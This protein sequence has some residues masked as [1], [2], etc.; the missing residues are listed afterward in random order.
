MSI[1][2]NLVKSYS[3]GN[4]SNFSKCLIA[5]CSAALL[6]AGTAQAAATYTTEDNGATLVVTV[7]AE[8]ATLDSSQIVAGVTKIAKRGS[9]K[10]TSVDISSYTGDFDIEEG[11]WCCTDAKQFGAASKSVDSGTI[12]VRDGASI[13][14]AGT[15]TKP[16]TI[17]GKTVHLYGAAA[18]GATSASKFFMSASPSMTGD[19][20]GNHTAFVLHDNAAFYSKNRTCFPNATID[21]GGHT[22][23]L[24][25]NSHD[26]GGTITNGGAIVLSG[27]TLMAESKALTFAADCAANAYVEIGSGSTLNIKSLTTHANGW[28]L[29]NKGGTVTCNANNT[30]T[31]TA[32]GNWDGPVEYSGSA[33]T[34]VWGASAGNYGVRTTVFNINGAISGTGTLTV[35]PGW[36]NLHGAWD[37]TYSGAVTVQGKSTKQ[38]V[39]G[40]ELVVYPGSGG[41]GVWNGAAAFTNA[42]S[43][44]LKDSARVEFMDDVAATVGKLS[45]VGDTST[46][47]GDPGDDTQSIKG[48]SAE[49]RSTVDGFTKTGTNTLVIDTTAHFTGTA[50]VNE[51]TLK[52]PY[53][54]AKGTPGLYETHVMP[55]SPGSP[56]WDDGYVAEGTWT[57]ANN[58]YRIG[59]PWLE[60]Y[61]QHLSYD[62]KG[63]CITGPQRGSLP[64]ANGNTN[65]S[66]GYGTRNG[67][68]YRGYIWNN[69]D[70]PVTYTFWH[71]MT[72][73]QAIYLGED[74]EMYDFITGASSGIS[75]GT[76]SCVSAAREITFQPGAT[77]I[78]VYVW[79]YGGTSWCQSVP[80][81]AERHGFVFAP[82]LVCSAAELNEQLTAYYFEPSTAN[83]NALSQLLANFSDF[84]DDSGA[85]QLF[86]VDIYGDNDADKKIAMQPVFDDLRFV[87]GTILDLDN[88]L[89]FCVKGL[90][91]SPIVT[92]AVRFTVTNNWTICAADFPKADPSIRHSMTVDGKLVF[93]E[94]ATFSVD[95]D[96]LIERSQSGI[97]VA[98][99][100]DGIVGCP[101]QAAG[102]SKKW[103]L[104][105]RGNDLYLCSGGGLKLFL[106]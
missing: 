52:I 11:I 22:L 64:M 85:G 10:L 99:A 30:P 23:T 104:F 8:G 51:G 35:G 105:V 1:L 92:N 68:W 88:N 102:G 77:P 26:F 65:W 96:L 40:N 106:R 44:T 47:T 21:L 7:D 91:G 37:N 80:S 69:T 42:T 13:E 32:T 57:G 18:S 24:K 14:Y 73:D 33:K 97:V 62:E 45:F 81:N 78:D 82:S 79:N 5:F 67:W 3:G 103:K 9:G 63:V 70:A 39:T 20:F 90:T 98:T 93:A 83:T 36:L 56:N 84:R 55:L 59:R 17:S 28:T 43:I 41:I 76:L 54:S 74:H 6:G 49:S 60:N 19:G 75:D 71:G 31:A 38:E 94:G 66:D 86:T 27:A 12:H 2:D 61:Q 58:K 87:Y 50:T 15:N 95:D 100:T 34:V 53:R 48:G 101:K 16:G 46:F 4:R 72:C 25:S 29:K 89:D